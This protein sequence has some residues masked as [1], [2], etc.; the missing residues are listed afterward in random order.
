MNNTWFRRFTTVAGVGPRLVCFPHAGGSATAY[1]HLARTLPADFDVLSVQYPG[2]QDRYGEAPFTDLAPLVEAVAEELARE[3]AAD[4]GRP[5]ALFGH[6]MGS[7][8]AFETARLLVERELPGPQRLFLSGRGGAHLPNSADYHLFDDADVLAD[9]RELGGTDQIML[10]DPEILRMVLPALRADYRALG[11]Y[12]FVAGEPLTA[13]ITALTG[14]RDPMVTVQEARTWR[15]HT[16]G[17]FALK[18]FPGG[19]F[20]LAERIGPVAAAV[21]EGLLAGTAAS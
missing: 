19:H 15:E 5:Y 2:R 14:D 10:D 1:M 20:Y 16:S 18:V 13:P 6:S 3:L 11:T 21:T 7:L 12:R 17:D 4:P 9:V 8:V